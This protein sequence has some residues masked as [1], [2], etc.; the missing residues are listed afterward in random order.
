M[1]HIVV[2][3]L[4]LSYKDIEK[5]INMRHSMIMEI[6]KVVKTLASISG[7]EDIRDSLNSQLKK[8]ETEQRQYVQLL[9]ALNLVLTYYNE[10]EKRIISKCELGDSWAFQVSFNKNDFSSIANELK[11]IKLD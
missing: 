3:E 7:V 10:G 1:F 2:D 4:Q 6:E 8:L 9:Q 11:D 5:Q